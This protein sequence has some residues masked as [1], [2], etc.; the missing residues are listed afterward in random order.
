VG[1]AVQQKLLTE[2]VSTDE[3]FARALGI[4]GAAA[5]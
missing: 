2:P 1:Y 4:L 3:V 5:E